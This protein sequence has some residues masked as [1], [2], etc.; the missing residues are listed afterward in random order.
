M[1]QSTLEEL[2]K[3][4]RS[5]LPVHPNIEKL[6]NEMST[7]A[8]AR[9]ELLS[10]EGNNNKSLM[11]YILDEP[12]LRAEVIEDYIT[13]DKIKSYAVRLMDRFNV[14]LDVFVFST[15]DKMEDFIKLLE[16]FQKNV[17][18]HINK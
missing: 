1:K 12:F 16:E 4:Y 15:E 5:E 2:F 6:Y 9:A 8:K 17:N 3:S 11:Q 10:Q 13:T 18:K 7:E 14:E